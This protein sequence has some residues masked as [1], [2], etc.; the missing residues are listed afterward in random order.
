M[1]KAF[2]AAAVIAQLAVGHAF[3]G[4][5]SVASDGL[6]RAVVHYGDLNVE[7]DAGRQALTGRLTRAARTVC[8]DAYA[9]DLRTQSRG[10]SCVREA[11]ADALRIVGQQRLAQANKQANERG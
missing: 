1:N 8:P 4:T 9:R 6:P 2:L 5:V 10:Q 3:A 7:S 11:V